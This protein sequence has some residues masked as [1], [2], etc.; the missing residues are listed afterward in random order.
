MIISSTIKLTFR[1]SILHTYYGIFWA[2][3]TLGLLFETLVK[4][5]FVSPE[6]YF[7]QQKLQLY[8]IHQV[9]LS[10]LNYHNNIFQVIAKL[11][12][13][14]GGLNLTNWE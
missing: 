4:Y 12:Y 11:E 8:S 9:S 5:S 10:I 13:I 6:H 7:L 2:F 14:I 1:Q 3:I